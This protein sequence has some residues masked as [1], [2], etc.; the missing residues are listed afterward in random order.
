MTRAI[1]GLQEFVEELEKIGDVRRIREPVD[2]QFE[3]AAILT[4]LDRQAG[5]AIFFERVNGH[6]MPIIG[7]LLAAPRRL[8]YALC[9]TEEMLRNGQLPP[10]HDQLIDPVLVDGNTQRRVI[11]ADN[12]FDI[13]DHL[14]TLTHYRR[15]SAPFITCGVASA[16]DPRDGGLRRGLHRVEVRGAKELGI[17]FVNPPLAGVYEAH[18]KAGSPMEISIA[19]GVDPAILLSSVFKCPP[20]MD[21]LCAAGGL[22][23]TPIHLMHA[24]TVDLEIPAQAEVVIEGVI[25]PRVTEEKGV[26]GEVS[27][28]YLA[29]SSPSIT[30]TAVTVRDRPHF[31][32]LLPQGNEVDQILTF[33]HGLN[34]IP[35]MKTF[36]PSILDLHFTPGTFGSHL[37]MAMDSDKQGEARR[38]LTMA[39]SMQAIKKAVI[40]NGDVDIRDPLAVEWALATRFQADKD[41]IVIPGLGGQVLDPS[42]NQ[43]YTTTKI[44]MDATHP[45]RD[46]FE[47]IDFP[48]DARKSAMKFEIATTK[49]VK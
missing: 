46:G 45:H 28:Y 41:L 16:R 8:A 27:G 40:V 18:K 4:R 1:G 14:P 48:E 3:A 5:P 10:N 36:F 11:T 32:A 21:K 15:D 35:K 17:S 47:K 6:S 12:G 30:I 22:I 9:M 31:Q 7:N 42:A 2:P 20:N 34:V 23:G 19:I 25:D 44:G 39:L 26:L 43:D 33:I 38:A 24:H 13:R 29:F 37:V 49:G